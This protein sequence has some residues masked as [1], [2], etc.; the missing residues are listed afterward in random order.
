L[1]ALSLIETTAAD[2]AL[3]ELFALT[4]R[5]LGGRPNMARAMASS[6]AL[7][8]GY[9]STSRSACCTFTSRSEQSHRTET[10]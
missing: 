5:Q 10:T 9:A 6:P 4:Q 1:P 3:T 2:P 7:L 8:E